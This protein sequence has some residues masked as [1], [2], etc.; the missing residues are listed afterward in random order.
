MGAIVINYKCPDCGYIDGMEVQTWYLHDPM[1]CPECD[2]VM[3]ETS[4]EEDLSEVEDDYQRGD[5]K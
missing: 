5:K 1:R 2:Q 3:V 4:R